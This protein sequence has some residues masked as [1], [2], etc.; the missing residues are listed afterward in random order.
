MDAYRNR[1]FGIGCLLPGEV[2]PEALDL[3]WTERSTFG[4]FPGAVKGARMPI[5]RWAPGAA[6]SP[7]GASRAVGVFLILG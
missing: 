2:T 5:V 1:G 4:R 7:V 6:I 3:S